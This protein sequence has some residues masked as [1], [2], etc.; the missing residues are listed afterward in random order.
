MTRKWY[1]FSQSSSWID[2]ISCDDMA[3]TKLLVVCRR[4]FNNLVLFFGTNR[5]DVVT[6]GDFKIKK[7]GPESQNDTCHK[8]YRILSS[9]DGPK[10]VDSIVAKRVID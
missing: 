3:M 7:D 10:P 5:F 4:F 6:F 9:S 2:I 8:N 1:S